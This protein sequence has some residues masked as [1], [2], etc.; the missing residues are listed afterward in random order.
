MRLKALAEIYTMHS[1]AP[2]SYLMFRSKVPNCLLFFCVGSQK[3]A[4]GHRR[5]QPEPARP[6]QGGRAAAGR[7]ERPGLHRRGPVPPVRVVLQ[8][9]LADLCFF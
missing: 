9:H 1:F 2:F 5:E 6:R 8:E 4:A 7:E 3:C